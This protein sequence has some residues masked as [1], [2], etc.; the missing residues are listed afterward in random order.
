[1]RDRAD[2]PAVSRRRPGAGDI[3]SY[4]LTIG[5]VV[6]AWQIAIQPLIQRAPVEA[7]IRLAPGSPLVLRRA[8]ESELVAGRIDNAAALGRDALGRAPFDVQAL[9]V[10][11]LTEARAGREDAVIRQQVGP[12][13]G[14]RVAPAKGGPVLRI[15]LSNRA[16]PL[17]SHGLSRVSRR[18]VCAVPG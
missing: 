7:A 8:A 5:A 1:L 17:R 15:P 2:K 3:A 16:C 13:A 14:T 18:Q 10:V 9:R 11:G 4:G 12:G 6:L